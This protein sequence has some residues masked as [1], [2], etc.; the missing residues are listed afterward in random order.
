MMG[1]NDMRILTQK[2]QVNWICNGFQPSLQVS[3]SQVMAWRVKTIASYLA[4]QAADICR[5]SQTHLA[6]LIKNIGDTTKPVKEQQAVLS[7]DMREVRDRLA[8]VE[9]SPKGSPASTPP[10]SEAG[11]LCG[12]AFLQRTPA[13]MPAISS[14][15]FQ[16]RHP[17]ATCGARRRGTPTLL[18]VA[19][20]QR[21]YWN[22]LG[23]VS[24]EA[25]LTCRSCQGRQGT[26]S[27][28]CWKTGRFFGRNVNDNA[29][30]VDAFINP[31]KSNQH[32]RVE[33]AS[34]KV[35][36]LLNPEYL[37]PEIHG[38]KVMAPSPLIWRNRR[39]SHQK[40]ALKPSSHGFN[41]PWIGPRLSGFCGDAWGQQ[42]NRVLLA[43]QF[44]V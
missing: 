23:S 22:Q 24:I 40:T 32:I 13:P 36:D 29:E 15:T 44:R 21:T 2:T 18:S 8:A 11:A 12:R 3:R 5:E 25:P 20:G 16:N 27:T 10:F 28:Q 30:T 1:A 6:E 33:V 14:D 4:K 34:K 31:D 7:K 38:P 17:Q 35:K 37:Q 41:R 42:Y 19:N 39:W 9:A 43:G 26:W